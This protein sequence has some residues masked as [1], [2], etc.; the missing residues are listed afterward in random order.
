M[1]PPPGAK[2]MATARAGGGGE[3][4]NPAAAL[5]GKAAPDFKLAGAD[6]KHVSLA[7]LKGS[8]VILDFWATWC[9]P[10]RESLPHL[11][12]IYNDKKDAGLKAY[13]VNLREGK[14][15]VDKFA[16]QSKL[17]I[18]VL[19]DTD[20]KVA[21]KFNVE[22]IPQ[23]VVIGKDGKVKKV[24]VGSGTHEKVRQAVEEAMK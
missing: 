15:K 2:D 1:A 14:E 17:T 20:G 22:G 18:P 13:A 9:G 8:V 5:E 11:N 4:E 23:T 6:G 10:C 7:D 12:D 16:E 3:E 21:E 19:F 24:V